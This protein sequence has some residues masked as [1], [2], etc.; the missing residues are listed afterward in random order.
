MEKKKKKHP[1]YRS[2]DGFKISL[3]LCVDI[4]SN[5]ALHRHPQD[6]A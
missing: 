1:S 5:S 4:P 2:Q 3:R 6:V